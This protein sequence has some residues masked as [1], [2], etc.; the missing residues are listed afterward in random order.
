[1]RLVALH[2]PAEAGFL[3]LSRA[4]GR[5]RAMEYESQVSTILRT[6]GTGMFNTR[7]MQGMLGASVSELYLLI[8][9]LINIERTVDLCVI[10]KKEIHRN[11]ESGLTIIYKHA[12][13]RLVQ[14]TLH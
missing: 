7:S 10:T 2:P 12:A 8:K 11:C 9:L 5:T 14:H 1:M 13:H 4:C 3:P 6:H